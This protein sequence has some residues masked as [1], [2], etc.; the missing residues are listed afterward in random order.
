MINNKH[1]ILIVDDNQN[2]LELAGKTLKDAGHLVSLAMDADSTLDQIGQQLPDLILLDIMMPVIDGYQLC[3]MI[4]QIPEAFRIPVIFLTAKNEVLDLKEGF[5]AGGVDYIVKPFRRDEL[6]ARVKS[7][8][9]LADARNTILEMVKKRERLYSI[10][11]HDIRSP[12]AAIST[13][14]FSL[15]SGYFSPSGEE[16]NEILEHLD[17][18]SRDTLALIDN[19]LVYTRISNMP[20]NFIIARNNLNNIILEC[21]EL[22]RETFE[23]K[24]I[25]IKTGLCETEHA[26]FDENSMHAI[27]RNILYNSIKFTPEGG[28]IVIS[29]HV[30][31]GEMLINVTDSGLGIPDDIINRIFI[32]DS[33]FTSR[34][35]SN[36]KGSGLG[37]YIIKDFIKLNNGKID[38]SS[39]EGRGTTV[40]VSIPAT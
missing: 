32:E 25:T 24:K 28:T 21:I 37:A 3:R 22:Y 36:E 18:A 26:L 31:S 1:L 35:T 16:Y 29:T 8:L 10:L 9:E 13:T 30:D 14:I 27:F 15:R 6:V 2:N 39:S 7:H 20:D 19:M 4:K 40:V 12:L 34:G 11:A 33:H 23:N 38:V 5:D 17:Q